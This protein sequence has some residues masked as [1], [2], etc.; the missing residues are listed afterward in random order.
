MFLYRNNKI[1]IRR[2]EIMGK[3]CCERQEGSCCGNGCGSQENCCNSK[4]LTKEE[5]LAE[6]RVYKTELELEVKRVAEKMKEIEK[7]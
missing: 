5:K 2:F 4:P 1:T 7:Q 6:L 3:D